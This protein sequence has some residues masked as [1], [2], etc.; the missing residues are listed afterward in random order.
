MKHRGMGETSF[1]KKGGYGPLSQ[2]KR[3]EPF[4][5]STL[6]RQFGMD[7]VNEAIQLHL[8]E[9]RPNYQDMSEEYLYITERG[10]EIRDN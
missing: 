6:E 4:R 3:G 10:I 2:F 9:I 8:I 1:M 7:L 5:K